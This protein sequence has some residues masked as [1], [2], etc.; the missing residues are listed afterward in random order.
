V[1]IGH[2]THHDDERPGS[3]EQ[4]AEQGAAVEEQDADTDEKGDQGKAERVVAPEL[5]EP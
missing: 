4:P 1:Q 2:D 5:P 3:R